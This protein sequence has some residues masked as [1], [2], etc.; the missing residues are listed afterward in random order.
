MIP[1]KPTQA[2][3]PQSGVSYLEGII[4]YE[5]L[6]NIRSYI[7]VANYN[8]MIHYK[9]KVYTNPKSNILLLNTFLYS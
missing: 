5:N 8:N 2:N 4:S 9:R 6:H 7:I 3:L 1:N